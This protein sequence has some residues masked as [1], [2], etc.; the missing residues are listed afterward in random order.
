MMVNTPT[1]SQIPDPGATSGASPSTTFVRCSAARQVKLILQTADGVPDQEILPA[2]L[3]TAHDDGLFIS[4]PCSEEVHIL[5]HTTCLHQRWKNER[6][7][8]RLNRHIRP[9]DA[10]LVAYELP[11]TELK[12]QRIVR[13][14]EGFASPLAHLTNKSVPQVSWEI[15][16]KAPARH[17][18]N[19]L[20][21][22]SNALLLPR[23][24]VSQ[25]VL[26]HAKSCALW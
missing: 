6:S 4:K 20:F 5:E 14:W 25:D 1:A 18:N 3:G 22:F 21:V 24:H 11:I 12:I 2:I 17:C 9:S 16:S 23:H 26:H 7:L 13:V 10:V 19:E 8:H 15:A